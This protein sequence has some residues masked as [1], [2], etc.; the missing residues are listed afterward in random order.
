MFSFKPYKKIRDKTVYLIMNGHLK[1]SINICKFFMCIL[2][3]NLIQIFNF[4]S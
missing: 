4:T 1:Q 3:T 2:S